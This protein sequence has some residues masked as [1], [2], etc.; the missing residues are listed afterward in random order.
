MEMDEGGISM[1]KMAR[2]TGVYNLVSGICMLAF[3]I[4]ARLAHWFEPEKALLLPEILTILL[5]AGSG[6][7]LLRKKTW[8][9][10]F[11]FLALGMLLYAVML[12]C[13]K[14]MSQGQWGLALFFGLISTAS[15]VIAVCYFLSPPR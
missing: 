12:G 8:A 5:L 9:D 2:V 15:A 4:V 7:A 1:S 13:G 11:A 3:W 14:F 6:V 10:K